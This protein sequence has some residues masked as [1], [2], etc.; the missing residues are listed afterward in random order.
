MKTWKLVIIFILVLLVLIIILQNTE[1]VETHLL[2]V[3]FQLPRA[4]L[5]FLTTFIGF[6]IG[7]LVT[8][9]VR[10]KQP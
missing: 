3:S 10:R 2:F 1:P 7:V 9:R 5:L 6:V 8:I 4:L